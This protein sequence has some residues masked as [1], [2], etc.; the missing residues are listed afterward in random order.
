VVLFKVFKGEKA[1]EVLNYKYTWLR[2]V[3]TF[4][5]FEVWATD[6]EPPEDR[7]IT[8]EELEQLRSER[9]GVAK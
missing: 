1:P 9:E 7:I 3:D 8:E 6:G 5:E 4:E 2:K